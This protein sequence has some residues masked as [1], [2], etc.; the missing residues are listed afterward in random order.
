MWKSKRN[1]RIT[2][3]PLP[4]SAAS[5]TASSAPAEAA[6]DRLDDLVT[7]QTL[8]SSKLKTVHGLDKA[9]GAGAWDWRGRGWLVVAGS[10]WEV[11]GWG[12]EA[13]SP[14]SPSSSPGAQGPGRRRQ[15]VVT[16]FAS[17]LFTPSGL[18]FY[19]RDERG[20]LPWTVAGIKEALAASEDEGV[21]KLAGEVF[22][23]RMDG[24]RTD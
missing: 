24:A 3:A 5:T 21:R 23:V 1:V 22:E 16:Y 20:L 12:D 17:T 8:T 19:S 4:S 9:A 18:D 6:T 2:Y 15:W 13:A 7:Y 14:P 11:L 10:R